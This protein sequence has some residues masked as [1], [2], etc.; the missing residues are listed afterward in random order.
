MPEDQ[1]AYVIV[2]LNFT[3]EWKMITAQAALLVK[4]GR[5]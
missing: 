1:V 3:I 5:M 2:K 4:G